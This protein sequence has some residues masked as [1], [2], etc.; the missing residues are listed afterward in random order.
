MM[1]FTAIANAN[2]ALVKYWGKRNK[3]LILPQNSSISVTLD[4]LNAVTTV[5]FD[6]KYDKDIFILNGKEQTENELERVISTLNIVRDLANIQTKAKV[7]SNN[8]FPTAAGLASSAAGGAAI[9]LAATKAAGLDFSKEK[10]S[11]IARRNSGSASRSVEGGF[12]EWLKGEKEDG[13]DSFG[14][15]IAIEDHWPEFRI[16]AT[17]LT[18]KEKKIKSRVGMAK[19]VENCP[20]YKC[21]LASIDEDLDK[22][23]KGI[24]EKDFTTVGQ[25]AEQNAI[26]LHALMFTTKPAII[27]W[28]PETLKM[29][30][31]I[32]EWREQGLECYFTIDGG[33]QVKIICL[34]KDVEEIKKR[35]SDINEI[36]EI[37]VS[38]PG[39][40]AKTIEEHLF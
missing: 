38:K 6:D 24:L 23:R 5:E 11:I 40:A 17:I 10:L 22:V 8:N 18:T 20:Y 14:K 1:K 9:A 28:L 4:G 21:W 39:S 15:Q 32:P 2:I 13:S 29:V 12:V 33:P 3:E 35:L 16:I 31:L 30:H 27:Y 25:I 19:T 37:H 26:K 34:E 7:S 36:K